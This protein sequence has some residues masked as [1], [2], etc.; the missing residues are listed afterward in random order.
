LSLAYTYMQ[1][2]FETYLKSGRDLSGNHV[3]GLPEHQ[4][5]TELRYAHATGLYAAGTL[6]YTGAFFVD[7]ENTLK[8]EE[9]TVMDA[10]LGYQ[11]QLNR[12]RLEPFF[13]IRNVLDET[14]NSNV[15][16]NANGGRYFEPA[17]GRN[18]YGGIM[19]SYQ[20]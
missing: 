11:A 3:P 9:A 18:Y 2:E 19:L 15:R 8:T 20:W 16:I 1:A 4:L 14:Y 7:D 5:F 13:G 12:W 10:R 6:R 17:P